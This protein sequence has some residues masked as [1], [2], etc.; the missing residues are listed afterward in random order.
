[1]DE[2]LLSKRLEL[3]HMHFSHPD[4]IFGKQIFTGYPL[5]DEYISS[6]LLTLIFA[7]LYYLTIS[8]ISYLVFYTWG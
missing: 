4:Q 2:T 5:I 1:M 8:S 6:C 3:A 7:V